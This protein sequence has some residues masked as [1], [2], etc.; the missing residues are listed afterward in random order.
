MCKISIDTS[1]LSVSKYEEKFIATWM[2]P[3]FPTSWHCSVGLDILK[4]TYARSSHIVANSDT[5]IAAA[6]NPRLSHFYVPMVLIIRQSYLI[7]E[8]CKILLI[9]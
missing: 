3:L 8:L 6:L 9:C 1:N 4:N 7:M 5:G 2:L